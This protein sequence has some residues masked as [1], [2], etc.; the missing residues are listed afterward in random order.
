MYWN[1]YI[2]YNQ[3]INIQYKKKTYM[4]SFFSFAFKFSSRSLMKIACWDE[5]FLQKRRRDD[6]HILEKAYF[7]GNPVETGLDA[8]GA[9]GFVY[10]HEQGLE[11]WGR[12]V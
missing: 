7:K 3:K 10:F 2:F 4:V 8:F 11:V 9:E 1:L 12:K 5:S 6:N